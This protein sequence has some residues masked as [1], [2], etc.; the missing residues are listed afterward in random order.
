[1]VYSAL[2]D[3]HRRLTLKDFKSFGSV[4]PNQT[5]NLEFPD[6]LAEYIGEDCTVV[7]QRPR[8]TKSD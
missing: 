6:Y 5:F 7:N 8:Q 2:Q 3:V 4:L 1:M